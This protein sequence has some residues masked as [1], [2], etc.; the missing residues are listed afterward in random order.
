[1]SDPKFTAQPPRWAEWL[2]RAMLAPADRDSV[3]R[4]LR[5][6][7]QDALLPQRGPIHARAWYVAQTLRFVWRT[8]WIWGLLLAA[9]V[10]ASDTLDWWLSPTADFY[11]RSIVSISIAVALFVGVGIRTAWRTRSVRSTFVVGAATGFVGAVIA[12]V[13]AAVQLAIRHD[14]HTMRMVAASGGF[15]E[16]F[17]LPFAEIVPGTICAIVGGVAGRVLAAVL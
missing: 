15:D 17:L 10:A 7:Y 1:M 8:S 14:P 4:D 11:A 12:V 16:I 13:L 3:S 9:T 2:V 6:Q 5:K